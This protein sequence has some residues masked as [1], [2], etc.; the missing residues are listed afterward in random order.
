MGSFIFIF[1]KQ[2]PKIVKKI[3]ASQNL[4][5]PQWHIYIYSC[6]HQTIGVILDSFSLS[7]TSHIQS[8]NTVGSAFRIYA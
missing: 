6:S 1:L 2:A 7:L 4:S 5:L 3:Q 8:G